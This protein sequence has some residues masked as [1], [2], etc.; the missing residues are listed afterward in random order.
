M[1]GSA[2]NVAT[3]VILYFEWFSENGNCRLN[4]HCWKVSFDNMGNEL[5]FPGALML[6]EISRQ[7]CVSVATSR[8]EMHF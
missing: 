4:R 5:E 2:A 8:P 1:R 3:S 6:V 7:F